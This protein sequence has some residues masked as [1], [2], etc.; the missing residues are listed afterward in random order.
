MNK[1][2]TDNRASE[3]S[4]QRQ[5]LV[6]YASRTIHCLVKYNASIA[7]TGG[8]YTQ[9]NCPVICL[10]VPKSTSDWD[11]RLFHTSEQSLILLCLNALYP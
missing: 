2:L 5:K 10:R 4:Q 8:T 11:F 1:S 7:E 9:F 6:Q 3:V